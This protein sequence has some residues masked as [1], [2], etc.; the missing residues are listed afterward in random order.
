MVIGLLGIVVMMQMFSVFEG[1]KRTTTGGDDAISSGAIA[2]YGVQRTIQ[3]SGWGISALGG[4]GEMS[5]MGCT[6]VPLPA[7]GT[8]FNVTPLPLVPLTINSAL[9]TGQ[10][11]NTDT[12]LVVSGNGSGSVEGDELPGGVLTPA[13][14]TAFR[15]GDRVVSVPSSGPCTARQLGVYTASTKSAS[16]D[17]DGLK[18][19]VY[20][21]GSAPTIRGYAIR[22]GNL[23]VCN[24][25]ADDCVTAANNDNPAIWVPIANNIVS[26]R[27]QYGRDT[28]AAEMD[29]VVDTWDQTVAD[30]DT[31][32]ST[33][34]AANTVA[35]GLQRAPV[36]RIALLARSSQAEQTAD[37]PEL[38]KHVTGAAPLWAGSDAVAQAIDP[39]QAEAVKIDLTDESLSPG[40]DWPTWKDFRY[41]VFET[42]V[43]LRNIN[44]TGLSSNVEPKC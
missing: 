43:P 12:L 10:D 41:K 28:S 11:P 27:A 6:V 36:I 38:E 15:G 22:N 42:V 35:C 26:L 4:D 19:R 7:F 13:T 2:L 37:W 25:F 3:Q 40:A 16:V 23:T 9:I 5:L 39:T 31:P 20:N 34:P 1:Q 18:V 24:F 33:T 8:D 29:G 21:L 14:P 17:A 32:V 44:S 30:P